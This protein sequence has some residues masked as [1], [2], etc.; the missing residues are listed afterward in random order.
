LW[1]GA[2][3]K[4]RAEAKTPSADAS[5]RK[6]TAYRRV[7]PKKPAAQTS[8]TQSSAPQSQAVKNSTAQS[9]APPI[10]TGEKPEG[11]VIGLT[12]W[13][14]RAS[15]ATDNKD[16]R[17]LLEDESNKEVEWTPERV[18]ADTIFAAGDRVKLG[19]ESPRNGYLYV[20]D[21]E[22]YTDGTV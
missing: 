21:R 10:H 11:E 5:A 2:F 8:T 16:A 20:I 1:D 4:K 13:R 12:I 17:L 6:T 22:Q 9:P 3:L 14:L 19:I 15:R 18:E 7:T